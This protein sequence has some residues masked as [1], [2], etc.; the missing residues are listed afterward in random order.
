MN[1]FDRI[2]RRTRTTQSAPSATS[3]EDKPSSD[4]SPAVPT[5]ASHP[6]PRPGA[7]INL[8]LQFLRRQSGL[9]PETHTDHDD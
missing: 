8:D 6:D 3:L 2:F 9:K 4:V 7:G 1:L 5:E